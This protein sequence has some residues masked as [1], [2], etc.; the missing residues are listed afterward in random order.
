MHEGAAGEV[1]AFSEAEQAGAGPWQGR[2]GL[3]ARRVCVADVDVEAVAGGAGEADVRL[4]AAGVFADVGESLLHDPVRV[5]G[6]CAGDVVGVVHPQVQ[7][8]LRT[9]PAGVVHE[10][11]DVCQ[12]RLWHWRHHVCR[13]VRRSRSTPIT[14]RSSSRA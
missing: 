2:P 8:D 5:A 11:G 4:R 9:C 14:V 13:H 3:G 7:A 12:G 10:P 6:E 1:D